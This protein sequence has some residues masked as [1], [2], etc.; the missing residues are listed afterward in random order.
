MR[1]LGIVLV[2][3]LAV[4]TLGACASNNA[5]QTNTLP[6]AGPAAGDEQPGGGAANTLVRAKPRFL[7]SFAHW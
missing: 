5:P 3:M 4:V 7:D 2:C 6:A 1:F